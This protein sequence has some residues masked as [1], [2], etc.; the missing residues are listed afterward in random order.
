MGWTRTGKGGCD[1]VKRKMAHQEFLDRLAKDIFKWNGD[2]NC[3]RRCSGPIGE[4]R[5]EVSQKEYEIVGWCQEC[6]DG[7]YEYE[8]ED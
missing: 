3:C 5:D 7:F 1:A 2:P 8:W 4:F 6:Q